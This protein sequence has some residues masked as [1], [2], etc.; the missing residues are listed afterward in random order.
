MSLPNYVECEMM[1]VGHSAHWRHWRVAL[2]DLNDF[3][4]L[5]VANCGV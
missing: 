1:V 4:S 5:A 3:F 2:V